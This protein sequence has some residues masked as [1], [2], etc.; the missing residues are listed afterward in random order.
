[1]RKLRMLFLGF[2]VLLVVGFAGCVA[3]QSSIT[4]TYIPE[5]C[6]EYADVNVPMLMP[7]TTLI[8]AK[9]VQESMNLRKKVGDLRYAWMKGSLSMH[10]YNAEQFKDVVFDPQG[11]VGL[12]LPMLSGLGFGWLGLSKPDDKKKVQDLEKKLNGNS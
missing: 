2:L 4:P 7:Y 12:L 1:M 11:P 9:Y 10:I 8:D 5:E 6:I 3:F